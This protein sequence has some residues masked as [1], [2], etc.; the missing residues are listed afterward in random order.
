MQQPEADRLVQAA[1]A[2]IVS[3]RIDRAASLLDAALAA[4]PNHLMALTRKAEIANIRKAFGEALRL[5]ETV[6]TA[7]PHFAPAWFEGAAALWGSARPAEAAEA[8]RRAA[9]I[10]PAKFDYRARH[11]AFAAWTG[12]E[13]EALA[14]IGS[15]PDPNRTDPA[16]Y[17]AAVA[18][19]GEIA[20]AHGRFA[21]AAGLLEN[22]LSIGSHMQ[23]ARMLHDMNLLRLGRFREGWE[24]YA[25]REEI[26]EFRTASSPGHTPQLRSGD[27]IGGKTLLIEDDQGHGDAIQMFRYL[28]LLRDRGAA[29]ITWRTFPPLSRLFAAAAPDIAIVCALPDDAQFGYRCSSTNLPR[30]FGTELDSIPRLEPL[31]APPARL[32]SGMKLPT[33]RRP[34]VGLVWSGDIRH[35]R[36]HL[37][38]IPAGLFLALAT[39][40]GIAFYSLQHEVRPADRDALGRHTGIG[41]EIEKA[42]DFADTAALIGRLDLVIAVDTGTAHLA[43]AMGKPTWLIVH[44]VPDWRWMTERTDSPWY[45][46]VRV[47]RVAPSEWPDPGGLNGWGP[48]IGRVAEALRAFVGR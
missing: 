29:R 1:V 12:D 43:A 19:T 47:F 23:A 22:A 2:E 41:R 42:V 40:P 39:V 32:K 48:V 34:K 38:S 28:P 15:L 3:R 44:K 33:G 10:Q 35:K 36:D 18:V 8:A 13:A 11:A 6:L 45:P 16:S 46:S 30:W 21:E 24:C 5:T 25:A 4:D 20:I 17:A 7:E 26:P 27:D 9:S 37:R 14:A 31:L